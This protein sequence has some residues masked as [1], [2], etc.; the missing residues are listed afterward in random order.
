[1]TNPGGEKLPPTFAELGV[2]PEI[3]SALAENDIVRTFAIQELTL[4]LALAGEDVIG[5][6]RTGTGKTL[7][8]GVPLLQR[9]TPPGERPPPPPRARPP[10]APR[11]SRRRS[12][13]SRPASCACRSPGISPP[14]AS[15]GVRVVAIYGGRAY[16]PQ[17]EALR[18][19][20]DVIVGTPGRLLDLAEQRHL[21]LGRVKA[22]VLDEADEMLD[23][24]FLPDVER[25]LRMLP[26]E[27][28]TMLFSATMPGP[29]VQLSRAF[30]TR[31][32]HIRAEE[33]D[34]GSI[35][36]RTKQ[37][38]Y[39]A[40]AMDKVELVT[41]ALQA[42][43]RGLTMIFTRTKRT[44]QRVADDLAERGFAA[45]AVHG[46]LGQG[47]REQALRAFRAEKVDVLVATDVAA[48]GIDVTGVT[49]VINYQCPEDAKTYVHRIGRTGRAGREG[50]AVTLVDWDETPRWKMISDDL[51]LGIDE[52]VETYSTSDHLFTDL[53]I[54]T[55]ASG[56]LPL[57]ARTR[58]GLDAEYIDS[59]GD[60]QGARKPRGSRRDG[61]GRDGGGR[62]GGSREAGRNGDGDEGGRRPR[63][64][65]SRSR[66]RGGVAVEAGASTTAEG[67]AARAPPRAPRRTGRTPARRPR[68]GR[69]RRA[70]VA[71]A[72]GRGADPVAASPPTGR[73]GRQLTPRVLRGRPLRDR[74][75]LPGI[76]AERRHRGDRLV[77]AV[78]VLLLAE[79]AVLYAVQ[80]PA[81]HTESVTAATAPAPPPPVGPVPAGFTELWRAASPDTPVPLA[82]GDGVVVAEGSRVSGR[83]ARTGAERWSY[84][85]DLPL[86]TTGFADGRV[87][88]LYRNDEYCSELSTLQPDSGARG[89]ARTLDA[90]PGT[91]LIG[92][93]PVLATGQDYVE[94]FRSDLVRTAEYG[95]VRALE[96]PGS[97]PR[98][99][100]TFG[101]FAAAE[102][103]AV[104]LERCPGEPSERL[105]VLRPSRTEGDRPAFDSSSVIGTDGA[106]VIAASSERVAVL[107]P[108]VPRLALYDGGGRGIGEFPVEAGATVA[109]PADGVARTTADDRNRYWW[110]GGR[111]SRWTPAASSRAGACPAPSAPA[112]ATATGCSC[113]SPAGSPT[114][115]RPPASSPGPCRWTA[116]RWPD[117]CCSPPR[118][119]CWSS[120]AAASSSC[121]GPPAESH[122]CHSVFDTSIVDTMT[123]RSGLALAVLSLLTEEPMHPYRMQQLIRERGKDDVVNVGQRSQLYKT[124]DRLARDGL[125]VEHAT[126]RETA[127]P[128]RT[129]YPSPTRAARQPR[130]GPGRCWPY[131]GRSSPSSSSASRT[132]PSS[133]RPTPPR[134]WRA[135]STP[136]DDGWPEPGPA[137]RR[138]R[139]C[140][141]GSC[142][143]SSTTPSRCWRPRPPGSPHSSTTSAAAASPGTARSCSA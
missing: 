63:R 132:C 80:S 7:G 49:H 5:Q 18:K 74:L 83:D 40:H 36:E 39:R 58:A 105:T 123:Q 55:T 50:V 85:R 143:S 84:E 121:W 88:A 54:P 17:L 91:R 67:A 108:G 66:T 94:T 118:A 128:E 65:R 79:V 59:D 26:E 19:G 115:T 133:P 71:V 99:G 1:M 82:V 139:A 8:F 14:R 125:I 114:S 93:D 103:R 68:A 136:C 100:C 6:A 111:P 62:D 53:D 27:R 42:K 137:T 119:P 60:H 116:A 35:H 87:L 3:V 21:V 134:R 61:G 72:A 122:P 48:R 129:L 25:I 43:D 117:R 131:R 32:T 15:L 69:P 107:L 29:I 4:P 9:I 104:I 77:A 141:R 75:P 135:A 101:S 57:S 140:C 110:T 33:A 126:E 56:R 70:V 113:P 97:Q 24:G 23:L 96:E 31:P 86:C 73:R 47:A 64:N 11:T 127:R 10:T 37:L 109:A 44:A 51:S 130:S 45:A 22:L 52:P 102:D 46:D 120:C 92:Q 16:E 78:L 2:R 34:Q 142:S 76:P 28:H 138:W 20:V 13:S 30:L 124:I 41:R 98:S 38:V 112:P 81:A 95:T 90:R 89:P 106:Q 12:S